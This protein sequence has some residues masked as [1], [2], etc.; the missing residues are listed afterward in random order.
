MDYTASLT[1]A[2]RE[3]PR[4]RF[5]NGEFRS[6]PFSQQL[7][8]GAKQIHPGLTWQSLCSFDR[9][10]ARCPG[11]LD[12]S[13]YHLVERGPHHGG[14]AALLRT[15]VQRQ[16]RRP[17]G[18]TAVGG[19]PQLRFRSMAPHCNTVE[20]ELSRGRYSQF[21]GKAIQYANEKNT[22]KKGVYL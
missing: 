2:C 9:R 6:V 20:G 17:Y 15:H 18:A 5:G 19:M 22:Q 11:T 16:P 3:V 4:V 7:N 1:G 21:F 10:A 8:G 13:I 12:W 14:R